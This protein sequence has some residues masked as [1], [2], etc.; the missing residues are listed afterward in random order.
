MLSE[1]YTI[2][3]LIYFLVIYN[4]MAAIAWF[5]NPM[6]WWIWILYNPSRLYMNERFFT[7]EESVQPI[8]I[9]KIVFGKKSGI[10]LSCEF[11]YDEEYI[12][13]IPKKHWI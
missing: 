2:K 11:E 1:K 9:T 3:M 12:N 8:N 5:S 4:A 6:L 10:I 7:Y 13:N